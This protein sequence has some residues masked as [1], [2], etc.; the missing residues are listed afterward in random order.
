MS[1]KEKCFDILKQI[2]KLTNEKSSERTITPLW[3]RCMVNPEFGNLADFRQL[4][5][6]LE[7]Q[8]FI[9]INKSG[10]QSIN[11][12]PQGLDWLENPSGEL[13]LR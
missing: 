10:D 4:I 3:R 12:T 11:I 13:H 1:T 7:N 8:N 9:S 6:V 2:Q 5:S